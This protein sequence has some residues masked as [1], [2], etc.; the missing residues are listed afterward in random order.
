MPQPM[1]ITPP[2]PRTCVIPTK[3]PSLAMVNTPDGANKFMRAPWSNPRDA[4]FSDT[5]R[6]A[7]TQG[8]RHLDATNV[9]FCDGHITPLNAP[10]T[11]SDPLNTAILDE[12][13]ETADVKIGFLSADNSPLRFEVVT[14]YRNE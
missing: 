8:F 7:G 14:G 13:N 11:Q 12:Y 9:A 6:R 5:G 4:D 2:G 1:P 10:Y 3:Q